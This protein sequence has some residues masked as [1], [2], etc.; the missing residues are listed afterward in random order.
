LYVG[1]IFE[2]KCVCAVGKFYSYAS[3][4][5]SV[6][7]YGTSFNAPETVKMS[8]ICADCYFSNR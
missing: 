7:Y 3:L 4:V 8:E 1:R 2:T 6:I 5:F